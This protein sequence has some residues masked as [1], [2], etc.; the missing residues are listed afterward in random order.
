MSPPAP[1]LSGCCCR[2]E[3][4]KPGDA[5]AGVA[6]AEGVAAAAV[7][8]VAAAGDAAVAAGAGEGRDP[9]GVLSAPCP[10]FSA[11][12]VATCALVRAV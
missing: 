6:G 11:A 7:A 2:W 9:T 10:A 3:V 1:V 12:A 4:G 8:A 5:A